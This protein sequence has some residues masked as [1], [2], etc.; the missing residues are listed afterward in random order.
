MAVKGTAEIHETGNS[1][2]YCKGTVQ[3]DIL[4]RFD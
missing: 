4:K 3:L 1:K 2:I